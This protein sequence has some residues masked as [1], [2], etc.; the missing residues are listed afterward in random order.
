[1]TFFYQEPKALYLFPYVLTAFILWVCYILFR[2]FESWYSSKTDKLIYRD[3]FIFRKL[4]K[5]QKEI[6][7]QENEFYQKLPKKEQRRFEH[8][9]K[10]FLD[11]TEFVGREGL[12]VTEKMRV[13]IA[14]CA[15][16]LT[17]GRKKYAFE[18]VDHIL[19]YPDAFYSTVNDAYHKGEFNPMQRTI[20]FSWKD[21][22]HGYK[23]TDD[24]LN[25]GI[26]EFVHALQIGAKQE[27]NIDSIRLERVFQ[28]ILK[29]LTNQE[30]KDKLDE[31]NYFRA[32]AFTNEYE[33]MA[34]MVEYF[35][36]SPEDF[37]NHFPQLYNHV[38]TMF[39]F[40]YAGY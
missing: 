30:V 14:A 15:M 35:F 37:K 1:M 34:V 8:R 23:V 11:E 17:F 36:E 13:L 29:R 21:F 39:N 12:I 5:K 16:M 38:R 26:H 27:N 40:R 6:L 2:M 28:R 9:M 20:V 10:V 33:F 32:Y 7:S 18:L 24:N 19:L 22:V 3:L 31:V 25:V 4:S